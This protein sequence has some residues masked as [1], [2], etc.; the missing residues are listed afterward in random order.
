MRHLVQY[1]KTSK[2]GKFDPEDGESYC[3]FTDKPG[4]VD[5]GDRVWLVSTHGDPPGYVLC[6]TFIVE[7]VREGGPLKYLVEGSKG[8]VFDPPRSIEYEPWFG[9]LRQLTGRFGFGLQ[10]IYDEE[11]VQGLLRV[12]EP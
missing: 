12:S 2:F 10:P 1:Q 7:R 4:H 6:M 3:V 11:V 5:K 9:R 8:Q